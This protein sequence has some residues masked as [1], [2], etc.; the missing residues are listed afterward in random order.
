[1][2]KNACLR[3]GIVAVFLFMFSV[4]SAADPQPEVKIAPLV[5]ACFAN[6]AAV[7]NGRIFAVGGTSG[8]NVVGRVD[9]LDLSS[10][11]WE[12]VGDL[13]VPRYFHGVAVVSGK[14]YVLGGYESNR[15]HTSKVEVYDSTTK[16]WSVITSLP[17]ERD[18]VAA[19]A[20]GQKIYLIGGMGK[21]NLDTVDVYDVTADRWHEGPKIPEPA[22]GV[23]AAVFE[24]K[25]HV[26]WMKKHWVLD[27]GVW[28]PL[29]AAPFHLFT[30]LEVVGKK[31]YSLSIG[32]GARLHVYDSPNDKWI[33]QASVP[34]Q[35]PS[36]RFASVTIRNLIVT[37]GGDGG[38]TGASSRVFVYDSEKNSWR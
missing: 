1:M 10:G 27:K 25:I 28:K 21:G 26:L 23:S 11:V 2:M 6:G 35:L 29:S 5:Q 18:R 3:V 33:P 7:L 30:R 16:K 34:T 31:L 32:K 4:A 36:F 20:L 12:R 15:K 19:V 24:G 37:L 22:H 17:R 14:I 38:R 13:N 9:S 8:R